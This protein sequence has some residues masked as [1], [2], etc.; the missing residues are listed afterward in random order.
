MTEERKNIESLQSAYLKTYGEEVVF[1]EVKQKGNYL[2]GSAK[3]EKEKFLKGGG[4]VENERNSVIYY[5]MDTVTGKDLKMSIASE[6]ETEIPHMHM[7]KFA[8]T[9]VNIYQGKEKIVH[10][11]AFTYIDTGDAEQVASFLSGQQKKYF[12]HSAKTEKLF[13][14]WFDPG[15]D[16]FFAKRVGEDRKKYLKYKEAESDELHRGLSLAGDLFNK[17]SDEAEVKNR[18][19][20]LRNRI[21]RSFDKVS[22][23]V[24]LNIKTEDIKMPDTIKSGERKVSKI[25]DKIS[26]KKINTND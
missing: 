18:V 4:G 8:K 14:E 20:D 13:K 19:S 16:E 10:F 23:K 12:S 11:G 26:P 3:K 2:I 9:E 7:D 24:G 17:F 21:A 25:I 5:F 15:K 1:D 22:A 6:G